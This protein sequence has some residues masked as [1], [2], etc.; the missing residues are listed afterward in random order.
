[1]H[2]HSLGHHPPSLC[3]PP[4]PPPPTHT[5]HPA[6]AAT[7]THAGRSFVAHFFQLY[8]TIVLP[9]ANTWM[10]WSLLTKMDLTPSYGVLALLGLLLLVF[11]VLGLQ[12]G[13]GG[14]G[15]G[16]EGR[17]GE[18]ARAS[19][20]CLSGFGPASEAGL[21]RC[22]RR[23]HDQDGPFRAPGRL[24]APALTTIPPHPAPTPP[25][26]LGPTTPRHHAAT[27]RL[28][29][30]PRRRSASSCTRRCS[31]RRCSLPP[32]ARATY[33]ASSRPT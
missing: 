28:G 6:R 1:M 20:A 22:T 19:A 7:A 32:A 3:L 12:V 33:A 11:L 21:E 27:H 13:R 17:R 31:W 9:V 8:R 23:Y 18:A 24:L 14:G 25:P 2:P 15:R 16:G 10:G 30:R 4:P 29:P 26:P 5:P